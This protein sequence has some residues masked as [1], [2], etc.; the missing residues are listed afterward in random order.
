M[1]KILLSILIV[2]AGCAAVKKSSSSGW[3]SLFDGKTLNN[4]RAS[5]NPAT[6]SVD[7]GMVIVHG[8]RAHLFYDGPVMNHD[9]KNFEWKASVMT[10]LGSNSGI[11]IHTT[12][13][14]RGWPSKGYEIQVNNSHTD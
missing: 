1:F 3:T 4:W 11:F 7:S 10:T 6:F 5:E 12:F 8:P 2:T 14:E 13:Q 9:F